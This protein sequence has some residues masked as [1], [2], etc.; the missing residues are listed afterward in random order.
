MWL[1][2]YLQGHLKQADINRCLSTLVGHFDQGK[3]SFLGMFMT[4]LD[5]I[6]PPSYSLSKMEFFFKMEFVVL[7]HFPPHISQKAGS[8]AQKVKACVPLPDVI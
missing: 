7:L 4:L 6:P 5:R 8:V 3:H 2:R 1:I